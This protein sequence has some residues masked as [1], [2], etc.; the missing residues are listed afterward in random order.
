M[1]ARNGLTTRSFQELFVGDPIRNL[2][3][4]E[5]AAVTWY[6]FNV[7]VFQACLEVT[8]IFAA[9]IKNVFDSARVVSSPRTPPLNTFNYCATCQRKW[10]KSHFLK[11]EVLIDFKPICRMNCARETVK[12][13]ITNYLG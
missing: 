1:R 8:P 3:R 6:R 2:Q 13:I 5:F 11:H 4:S 9:L 7:E 10:T 12:R